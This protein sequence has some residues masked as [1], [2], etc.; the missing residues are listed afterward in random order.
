LNSETI[1]SINKLVAG[2]G[3]TEILHKISISVHKNEIVSIIG[4]NGAGKSTIL[5][6]ILG[7]LDIKS[8]E[9]FLKKTKINGVKPSDVVKKGVGYVPQT[10]N[11]FVSLSVHENLEMGAWTIENNLN[12]KFEELY[13]LFPDLKDKKKQL[14]GQLSGG[15][16]QMLAMAKALILDAKVLLL[17]EPTAGLSPKYRLEIF[18]TIQRINKSGLPILM[19]EQN[20]KQALQISHRGYVL[21]DGSNRYTGTGAELSADPEVARMFLGSR[22]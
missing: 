7:T 16:R 8:G 1:L 5:K 3:E 13:N 21:V 19:V 18:D 4:P 11:V 12:D 10:D 6:A 17:D 20:A 15:Q 2:Y 9:I 22:G 14:A